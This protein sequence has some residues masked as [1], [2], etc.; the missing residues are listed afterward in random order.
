MLN[1]GLTIIGRYFS[2]DF[3]KAGFTETSMGEFQ[4]KHSVESSK[5]CFPLHM[6]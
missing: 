2:R 5:V 3:W 1:H 6:E 4:G